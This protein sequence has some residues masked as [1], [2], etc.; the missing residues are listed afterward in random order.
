M[1]NKLLQKNEPLPACMRQ[2]EQDGWN[3]DDDFP[4]LQFTKKQT[5]HDWKIKGMTI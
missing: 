4:L 1:S 2:D 3:L 5:A